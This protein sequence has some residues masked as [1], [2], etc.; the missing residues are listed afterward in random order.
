MHVCSIDEIICSKFD[1]KGFTRNLRYHD[2]FIKIIKTLDYDY[3]N[4]AI[5]KKMYIIVLQ[6]CYYAD[7]VHHLI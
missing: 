6:L 1:Q 3:Q 7:S 5:N 4:F 2:V